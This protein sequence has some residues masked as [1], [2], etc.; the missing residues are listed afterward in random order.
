[1]ARRILACMGR[2]ALPVA[3]SAA[4][5]VPS[6]DDSHDPHRPPPTSRDPLE[7]LARTYATSCK[8]TGVPGEPPRI[9]L[10]PYLTGTTFRN[11]VEMRPAR[12]GTRRVFIVEQA[13]RIL[14]A[15]EATPG[16]QATEWLN[17]TD[18]VVSGGE[19]GLL[20]MAFDP[21]FRTNGR[22][23][24]NYTTRQAGPLQ[25]RISRFRVANPAQGRP[26]P[27]SEQVLLAINQPFSNHN[28]G[29][30]EFGPDGYLYIG[31]GDGGSAG[32]PIDAG[33]RMDTLHGKM[34]RI[35]VR[36]DDASYRIPA[37]NPFYT[38]QRT[39]D[40][41]AA[42]NSHCRAG[43]L[44][45]VCGE[46]WALGLRNPW[47]FS[48]DP[49]DGALWTGDVGQGAREEV[50]IIERGKNY[51]WRCM[52]GTLI[53]NN[54]P[55]C[56]QKRT[57]R[58]FTPPVHEY[59]REDGKSIT[60]GHV[61]RGRGLPGLQGSYIFGDYVSGT[62][63]A[64]APTET[65][66]WTRTT[67]AT[68]V[69]FISAFGLDADNEI[70]VVEYREGKLLRLEPA[71]PNMAGQPGWPERLSHTGCFSDLRQRKLVPGALPYSVN[72]PL[73]SD[74]ADKERAMVL[75]QGGVLGYRADGTWSVPPGTI[76]IK[77]FVRDG[78]PLETR[79][80]VWEEGRVR[81][82]TYRW[83]PGGSEALLMT[84]GLTERVGD[85]D[86]YF[87]SRADCISC[88][89]R[90]AGHLLGLTTAQMNRLHDMF[91]TGAVNQIE[92]LARLGYLSGVPGPAES[93]ARFPSP[94][95]ETA[96]V[97]ERARAYIHVNCAGCHMPGGLSNAT[98]DVRFGT[99]LANSRA[100]DVPAQ[101]GDLG[102]AGA[103]IIAPGKPELSTFW[104]RMTRTDPAVRMPNIGSLQ[105]DPEGVALVR[106]W[107]AGLSG[108]P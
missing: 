100:C 34:L 48:F 23:Y 84:A 73:W 59:P 86:W 22:I 76:F 18:R 70:Y 30:I 6:A 56:Q 16:G 107:I 36:T 51:G 57:A 102:V 37:D 40:G 52:E 24:V 96:G 83:L 81:G 99:P 94:G 33:Q 45:G 35:D 62:V 66:A 9:K 97:T 31:M 67:L 87:P 41:T 14:V 72:V 53:H 47:R 3:L 75:P 103:R 90:A 98:I 55:S 29:Q 89:T 21:Q 74:G 101:M 78:A 11:P 95:D 85:K 17:L 80:L 5:T 64:L 54:E 20:G 19:T 65:G 7:G 77:T 8:V 79:F 27:T 10:T 60:G 105:P 26:D 68:D 82:A 71:A 1:M 13:G 46:I 39:A 104:L 4:C 32:D 49:F 12:D 25:T 42:D 108:C 2:L 92:A 15:P 61:Y 88:H 38:G 93:L 28:G 91:G 69:G 63:W 43:N 58:A 44:P 106:R 50:D